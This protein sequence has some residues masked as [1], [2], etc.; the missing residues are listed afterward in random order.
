MKLVDADYCRDWLFEKHDMDFQRW[1]DQNYF[2]ED[3]A[4]ILN[5]ALKNPQKMY[6]VINDFIIPNRFKI[7]N[8]SNMLVSAKSKIIVC[9]GARGKGKTAA[10]FWIAEIVSKFRDV[11]WIG[12]P[13]LNLPEWMQYA[14]DTNQLPVGSF[15]IIDETGIKYNARAFK[16]ADS[17]DFIKELTVLR[18]RGISVMVLTQNTALIDKNLERLCDII[19]CKP[20]SILQEATERESI[21]DVVI[22]RMLPKS[23]SETLIIGTDEA[24]PTH[25]LFRQPLPLCWNDKLSKPFATLD[26]EELK[27]FVK[28]CRDAQFGMEEIN[29]FLILRGNSPIASQV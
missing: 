21:Q 23:A 3:H 15:A 10:A 5:W 6:V 11:Y 26:D 2:E 18:H 24:A 16:N 22:P 28:K 9:V 19:V 13:S 1:L 7:R 12:I 8:V 29:S 20:F 17:I 25:T 27:E 4:H 14:R